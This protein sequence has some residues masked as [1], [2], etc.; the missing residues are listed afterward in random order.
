MP[1]K[2]PAALSVV[3]I[4]P[5]QRGGLLYVL[6][7]PRRHLG[8]LEQEMWSHLIVDLDPLNDATVAALTAALGFHQ[9]A[10]LAREEIDRAGMAQGDKPHPLLNAERQ[11][12][13]HWTAA[14]RNLFRVGKAS[15]K[16]GLEYDR[17]GN[18]TNWSSK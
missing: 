11:N 16:Q 6:P 15:K 13:L 10:R 8:K 9:R 4:P 12:T 7:A 1:R 14:L 5:L 17:F 2:S 18:P 3:P